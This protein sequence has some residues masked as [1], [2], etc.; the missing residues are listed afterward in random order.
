MPFSRI[1][2]IALVILLVSTIGFTYKIKYSSQ[3][4]L[5]QEKL[6]SNQ[7]EEEQNSISQLNTEWA[8]LESPRNI[9]CLE[10]KYQA[11]LELGPIE[12]QYILSVSAVEKIQLK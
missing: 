9:E 4:L 2:D 5:R 1:I 12:P 6:L 7:I 11:E 10:Q 3:K 8:Y